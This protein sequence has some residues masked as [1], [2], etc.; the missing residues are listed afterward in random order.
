MAFCRRILL[1]MRC[2]VGPSF[3]ANAG[4]AWLRKQ[5]EARRPRSD[6]DESRRQGRSLRRGRTLTGDC[7]GDELLREHFL[8]GLHLQQFAKRCVYLAIQELGSPASSREIRVASVCSG[9]EMLSVSLDALQSALG[10]QRC[11]LTFTVP[12]VCELGSAKRRWCMRVQDTLRPPDGDDS[13][14]CAFQDIGGIA[15][16]KTECSRHMAFCRA[17]LGRPCRWLQLQGLLE[18]EP[19]PQTNAGP[20]A[21]P[22]GH[23]AGQYGRHHEGRA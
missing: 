22:G 9:S 17:P 10:E 7:L 12:Y 3:L 20:R 19:E 14:P 1:N 4:M 18:S 13:A 6:D 8:N 5:R 21:H 2:P 23:L 16:N 15:N 11:A